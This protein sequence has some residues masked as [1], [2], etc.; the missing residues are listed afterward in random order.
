MNTAVELSRHD[1]EARDCISLN[2]ARVE[3]IIHDLIVD[4]KH[5][6]EFVETL[7]FDH[8]A[9]FLNNALIGLRVMA[10][11]ITDREKLNHIVETN[12]SLLK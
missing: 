11:T 4:G 6:G 12:M 2:W 5:T 8:H 7:D 9:C 10:K 1:A 3:G